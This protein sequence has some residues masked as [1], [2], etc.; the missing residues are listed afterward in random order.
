MIVDLHAS[1][2]E[3]M[4]L[5]RVGSW[6]FIGSK[7]I[8]NYQLCST[9]IYGIICYYKSKTRDVYA[10]WLYDY[11]EMTYKLLATT[12]NDYENCNLRN[13]V[14]E[15]KQTLGDVAI[16]CLMNTHPTLETL[17]IGHSFG[18]VS[19]E[20]SQCVMHST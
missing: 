19:R 7:S 9:A 16:Y 1:F 14:I 20:A 10:H 13:Q 4:D 11:E 8:I 6:I 12:Y 15:E 5:L 3:Y 17:Y 18:C 2:D